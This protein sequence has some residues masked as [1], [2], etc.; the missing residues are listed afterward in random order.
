MELM[1]NQVFRLLQDSSSGAYPAGIYRVVF[2]E[3]SI[4]K[5]VC[6][7]IQLTSEVKTIQGGR[8]KKDKT[9]N[10]RK[11]A[12]AALIGNLLWMDRVLPPT[13]N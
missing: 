9:K 7:C 5:T 2:D 8:R 6:V 12:P 13:E 4:N 3:K 1:S 10:P 11:K